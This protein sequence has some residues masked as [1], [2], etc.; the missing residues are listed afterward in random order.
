MDEITEKK[1]IKEDVG[2]D[3]LIQRAES[4]GNT[5]TEGRGGEDKREAGG[6]ASER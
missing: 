3:R 1:V 4:L 2:V 6:R 5:D